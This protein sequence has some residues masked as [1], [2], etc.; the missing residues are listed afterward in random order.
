MRVGDSDT[1]YFESADLRAINKETQNLGSTVSQVDLTD[2]PGA[3]IPLTPAEHTH[4]CPENTYQ[5]I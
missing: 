2:V 3:F 5:Y 4:P 1:F